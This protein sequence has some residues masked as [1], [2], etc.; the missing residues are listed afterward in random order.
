MDLQLSG[1]KALVTGGT[2]GLGYAV[3]ET[4]LKEGAAVCINS[5]SQSHLD[6]AL[7][8]LAPNGPVFAA[9]GDV[10]IPAEAEKIVQSAAVQLGGLDLL[11][12]NAGGPRTGRFES[13]SAED[14]QQAFQLT[15]LSHARLIHAALPFLRKSDCP[16]ILTV[17]SI[18]AKQPIPDLVLSNSLRAGLLGL[19]KSLALELGGENIR[20]NS[21]LPGFTL[22]DR[23][24]ELLADRAAKNNT[25]LEIETRKQ[26]EASALRRIATTQEFANA[27]VFLLSP[28]ASYLTGVMLSVDGG[29]YK[30]LL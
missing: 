19:T 7:R 30:G 9:R 17:T 8:A 26:T 5:R 1:K 15:F 21:I 13:I 24:N 6:E 10:S 27:A 29:S 20:V 3:A 11:V 18:S 4:L 16:S 25:S 22:T 23:A 28:A 14:W 2:R 12:T